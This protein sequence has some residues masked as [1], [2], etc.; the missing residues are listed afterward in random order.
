V[1]LPIDRV[2]TVK[3]FGTV[4]TG[5]LVSGTIHGEQELVVLPR[6]L[7]VK[8]RGVQVHGRAAETATAGN[9]V[10]LNLGGVEVGDLE[11][12]DTLCAR[13]AFDPSRRLD[14]LIDLL[15]DARA[16]KHG[17]RVRFHAGTSE[18]LGRVALAGSRSG[19]GLPA[20]LRSGDSAFARIRLEAPAVLT[21][22]DR[23][24]L[25]AYSPPV[26]IGGGVVLDPDPPR[27]AIRTAAARERFTR[28]DPANADRDAAIEQFLVERGGRG[29][30]RPA[31]IARGGRSPAEAIA[32]WDR[33]VSGARAVGVGDLLVSTPT[34][35]ELSAALLAAIGEH[36]RKQP[37]SDGLPREEARARIFGR[38]DPAVFDF[39]I[40]Q[41]VG[42]HKLVA[43]DRLALPSHHVSLTPEEARAYET[44]E[45]LFRN[46]KLAPP[47]TAA[48]AAVAGVTPAI[49]DR[50]VKLLLR[51][52]KL[53]K[54][55][56]LVFH[57][58]A[59]DILKSEVRG[60]K[61]TGPQVRVDVAS[62]KDRYGISRKYAIPLLEYLDRERVTRRVGD[63]RVVL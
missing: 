27:G 20:E 11:R 45:G 8:I 21:R 25:R 29:L 37:L 33:L 15:P 48:A 31:L 16:L 47:D 60:L 32:A 61:G 39:A 58:E 43:R 19:A 12:G 10:A 5:T 28:L 49:A 22:G 17:S 7:P 35:A 51:E 63:A 55:D 6:G 23:F 36:H 57:A 62:F 56:T 4:V 53:V 1:R 2:F 18:L 42:Q 52:R 50:M 54:V 9:R 38:A 34:I 40:A 59:L 44:L 3:G 14:V 26:T 24:I 13:G 30:A 46:A 41:L